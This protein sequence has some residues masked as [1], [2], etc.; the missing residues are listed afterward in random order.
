VNT[1]SARLYSPQSHS[2][3]L[4]STGSHYGVLVF[5]RARIRA[6]SPRCHLIRRMSFLAPR[7]CWREALRELTLR[8][9]RCPSY[10]A[11][12]TPCDSSPDPSPRS[13]SGVLSSGIAGCLGPSSAQLAFYLR[14]KRQTA[15]TSA[16]RV[17]HAAT[18]ILARLNLAVAP[19]TEWKPD[20]RR[21][22]ERLRIVHG[23]LGLAD[24]SLPVSSRYIGRACCGHL[25]NAVGWRGSGKNLRR[26]EEHRGK[27]RQIAPMGRHFLH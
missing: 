23:V 27:A 20:P 14:A 8:H 21:D 4:Q 24:H 5:L 15:S 25:K 9:A 16:A 12:S 11:E 7:V 6:D 1:P 2:R 13:P 26:P 22:H 19:T 10:G 17:A 3:S 18:G